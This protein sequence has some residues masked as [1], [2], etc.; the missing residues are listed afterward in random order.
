LIEYG[1]PHR[2][3]RPHLSR[4][5]SHSQRHFLPNRSS[6]EAKSG[7][8]QLRTKCVIGPAPEGR[9]E[10]S[11]SRGEVSRTASIARH[12]GVAR[13]VHSYT[14]GVVLT[15]PTEVSGFLGFELRRIRSR[16]GRWMVPCTPRG[17]KRTA[18]PR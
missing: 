14:V 17:K 12:V 9:L 18:L 7:R 8:I 5:Q 16:R 13:S 10:G 1:P 11:K 3:S 15:A 4:C 2:R 6:K